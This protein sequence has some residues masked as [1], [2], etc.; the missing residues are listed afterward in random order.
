M[1]ACHLPV[2]L[3]MQKYQFPTTR[4]HEHPQETTIGMQEQAKLKEVLEAIDSEMGKAIQSEDEKALLKA[5]T[6]VRLF[7]DTG[8]SLFGKQQKRP[9]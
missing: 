3:L 6:L 7:G 8:T 4:L 5:E 2:K 1:S 9:D